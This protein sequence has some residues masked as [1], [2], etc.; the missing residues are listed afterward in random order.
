MNS[1][2]CEFYNSPSIKAKTAP[3]KYN[4]YLSQQKKN[5]I[6]TPCRFPLFGAGPFGDQ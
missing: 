3:S 6:K 5:A 4:K 2:S 1:D